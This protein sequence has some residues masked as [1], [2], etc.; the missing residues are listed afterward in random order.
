MFKPIYYLN[1]RA[2]RIGLARPT[3][4]NDRNIA[5]KKRI[6]GLSSMLFVAS[7]YAG[8]MGPIMEEPTHDS[9]LGVFGGGGTLS[10]TSLTQLGSAYFPDTAGGP[11]GV[12]AS[13]HSNSQSE[14]IVGGQAGHY[15]SSVTL[16]RLTQ[17]SLQPGT[18]LEGYYIGQNSLTASDLNNPTPR[19][20]EHDF[21]VNLP[22]SAGV[23]LINA[24][25]SF[26]HAGF[27]RWHPYVAGGIG[28]AVLSVSHATS[29]QLSPAEPG[30]NH[31]NANTSASAT[32][33]ASQA[34]AGLSFDWTS[35][36]SIFGEYRYLYLAPTDYVFG[37]AVYAVGV[38]P[39]TSSW[40]VKLSSQS[41]N[42]GVAG[43]RY[44]F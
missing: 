37:S 28:A 14:A 7:G 39:E 10:K 6:F 12:N 24:V 16:P 23:G 9:Y 31:F 21:L 33:F 17:W 19:V 15:F 43:I 22:M 18:E 32:A 30:I 42:L 40:N 44:T 11:L 13:G 25:A 1:D 4:L 29:T 20:P 38:H 36:W 2:M 26:N 27:V 35:H 41:Y 3:Q 34:K 8:T 5:M